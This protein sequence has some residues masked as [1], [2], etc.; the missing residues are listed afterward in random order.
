MY[1]IIRV[2]SQLISEIECDYLVLGFCTILSVSR[3]LELAPTGRV[4]SRNWK[5]IS[6]EYPFKKDKADKR[7]CV[8]T[9][10]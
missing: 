6:V 10:W 2:E 3:E 9:L 8:F 7:K 4:V 5:D 1:H